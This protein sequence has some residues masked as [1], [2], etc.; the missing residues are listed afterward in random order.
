MSGAAR[1]IER[2]LDLSMCETAVLESLLTPLEKVVSKE[3]LLERLYSYQRDVGYNAIEVYIHRLRKKLDGS[4]L[5][6]R[7]AYGR[8]YSIDAGTQPA[9]E[10]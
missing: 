2:D 7:T 6:V 5:T 10:N 8:G 3:Q 9:A 1:A 4:G